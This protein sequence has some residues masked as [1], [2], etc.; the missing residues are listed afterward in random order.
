MRQPAI[1]REVLIEALR[2]V[3]KLP[4]LRTNLIHLLLEPCQRSTAQTNPTEHSVSAE[5]QV[6]ATHLLVKVSEAGGLVDA[7]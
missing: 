6:E 2:V 7:H 3:R 1:F 4:H 5:N